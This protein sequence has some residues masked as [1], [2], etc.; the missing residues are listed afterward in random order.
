MFML[1]CRT[2]TCYVT[3][4]VGGVGVLAFMLTCRTC[5]CFVTSGFPLVGGD[6][7]L[8][9]EAHGHVKGGKHRTS[10]QYQIPRKLQEIIKNALQI[11]G[12]F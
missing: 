5:T 12:E 3:F 4:W 9:E 10:F 7:L 8:F 6:W 2:C 1:T 11:P